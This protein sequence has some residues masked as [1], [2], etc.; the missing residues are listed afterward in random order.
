M[1]HSA[2]CT[3]GL[4]QEGAMTTQERKKR[5]QPARRAPRRALL[6]HG[7]PAAERTGAPP[8]TVPEGA[9]I[10]HVIAN[11]VDL[12]YRVVE[13]QL[14]QGRRAARHFRIGS[15]DLVGGQEV[16]AVLDRLLRLTKDATSAWLEMISAVVRT[17]G[18]VERVAP[19]KKPAATQESAQRVEGAGGTP[20]M[21]IEVK[22]ARPAEVTLELRPASPRFVPV[23]HALHPKP[24]GTRPLTDVK[25]KLSPDARRGVVA[26]TVPDDLEAGSY[27]GVVVDSVTD[28]PGGILRVRVHPEG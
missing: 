5:P 26:I 6:Q 13:E 17:E 4:N 24:P 25:F 23:V 18:G 3:S 20:T 11:A 27:T 9:D 22:S 15:D 12:G 19:E 1:S 14:Q 28:E 8:E 2:T 10:D 7:Q 16:T 21:S